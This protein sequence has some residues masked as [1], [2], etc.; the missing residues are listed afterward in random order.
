MKIAVCEDQKEEADWLCTAIRSWAA[1][2]KLPVDVVSFGDAASFLFSLDDNVYDVLS[3][4]I[5]MPGED[6]VTLA[7]RLRNMN[8]N[9][10]IVFVTG[11][12]E[13][14][15]EGYE[16]DAVNYLLK[17]VD[18]GQVG[19]C[20]DRIYGKTDIQQPYIILDTGEKM[21]KLLQKEIYI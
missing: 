13:Y 19:K 3:L 16:V 8:N 17:P 21:L 15:M 4:D 10:F 9:V 5:K 14:V 7:K 2:K 20:L 6:G 11:E 18:T 1:D 12:K